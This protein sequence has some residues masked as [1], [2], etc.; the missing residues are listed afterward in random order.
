M[1][2]AATDIDAR[3][4]P[5]GWKW[6]KL[7]DVS[8]I[9]NGY[10]FDSG[11]FSNDTGFPLIRIRDLK[12]DDPSVFF[13]GDYSDEYLVNP[14]ELLIGMDGEFRCYRWAGPIALQNQ[15][16]CRLLPNMSLIDPDFLYYSINDYL[17]AIE[18]Q[19]AFTTVKHISS[20]QIQNINLPLPPLEEQKRIAAVL[21]EQMAAVD[22]AK[23]AAE[24]R[25]AAAKAL[26]DAYLREVF[27]GEEA[28][29]WPV[30]KLSELS[31]RITKGESP[32]WQGY[33][34]QSDG[35]RYIKSENVGSGKFLD[36][37]RTFI[38]D[39]FDEKLIRS[40]L[41]PGDVLMNITGAS[42]GRACVVSNN[43]GRANVSQNVAVVT[44]DDNL[45]PS[46]LLAFIMSPEHQLRIKATE[47]AT[48]RPSISLTDIGNYRI[49]LPRPDEQ[50]QI[51]SEL[52]DKL[53]AV[54]L[55]EESIQ[56]ELETIEAMPAALLRKAFSG[57]L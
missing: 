44:T 9:K 27:E 20:R 45:S 48:A 54:K 32:G 57:E 11:R 7:G 49:P 34:Y 25:L 2:Q 50:N 14:G 33:G 39:A 12:T 24:E 38:S 46:Y 17:V 1:T 4:L 31:S 55:A 40:S 19:T 6:V 53:A 5:A 21:N 13:Q 8:G 3:P 52:E 29:E 37:P 30:G 10:A 42:I 35:V 43:L 23:K 51:V 36:E 47:K 26:P 15:R 18:N 22:K 16:V 56:Q 41:K 28:K